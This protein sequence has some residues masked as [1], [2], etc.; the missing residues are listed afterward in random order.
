[1]TKV[2]RNIN[3]WLNVTAELMEKNRKD[4]KKRISKWTI[5][6]GPPHAE[7]MLGDD[8][9]CDKDMDR[10]G[11]WRIYGGIIRIRASR[12]GEFDPAEGT[13]IT[14]EEIEAIINVFKSPCVDKKNI[15]RN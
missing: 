1:M 11:F 13:N 14:T 10:I 4:R 5:F 3:D 8:S 6:A 12:K 15:K 7:I 2:K 9:I